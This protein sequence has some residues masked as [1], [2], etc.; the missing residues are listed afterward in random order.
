MKNLQLS[1]IFIFLCI[2]HLQGNL[3]AATNIAEELSI[4]YDHN[5]FEANANDSTFYE[6]ILTVSGGVP[7]YYVYINPQ[8]FFEV[9]VSNEPYSFLATVGEEFS[10]FVKDSDTIP[11]ELFIPKIDIPSCGSLCEDLSFEVDIECQ[12]DGTKILHFEVEGANGGYSVYGNQ[13][14]DT[15]QIGETYW[16]EVVDEQGCTKTENGAYSAILQPKNDW[17]GTT[18][19]EAIH[20]DVL[21][22]DKG[23]C[24]TL[25]DILVSPTCGTIVAFDQITGIV[26]YQVDIG[27]HCTE[28]GFVYEVIDAHG[29]TAQAK[30]VISLPQQDLVVEVSRDCWSASEYLNY[31]VTVEIFS[32]IPPFYI[33]G[34]I[35]TTLEEL[36]SVSIEIENG[37]PYE[38]TVTD[39]LENIFFVS[40]YLN[41]HSECPIVYSYEY[42]N[43]ADCTC[44]K[45]LILHF[46]DL[47]EEG[48]EVTHIDG[49]WNYQNEYGYLSIGD[50]IPAN[51]HIMI[52]RVSTNLNC[53]TFDDYHGLLSGLAKNFC[54]YSAYGFEANDDYI[55]A[56][57]GFPVLIDV[58]ANDGGKDLKVEG[59]YGTLDCGELIEFN[60]ETGIITYLP[61]DN[62]CNSDSFQYKVEDICGDT[63]YGRVYI[64]IESPGELTVQIEKDCSDDNNDFYT[65]SATIL[66]G[67]PPFTI[68][69]S[70]NETL[71]EFDS[72]STSLDVNTP[73][74]VRVEDA[75][76]RIFHEQGASCNSTC[77]SFYVQGIAEVAQCICNQEMAFTL[78]YLITEE[79][80]LGIE[81]T[82][83]NESQ[84]GEIALGDTIPSDA[85]YEINGFFTANECYDFK[86]TDGS[87][88]FGWVNEVCTFV[89]NIE[90][91]NDV[92]TRFLGDPSPILIPVLQN[93][94]GA[95][96]RIT[97]I[98]EQPTCG[99][100]TI[101]NPEGIIS[102]QPNSLCSEDIFKYEVEDNCGNSAVANVYIFS[103]SNTTHL[104]VEVEEDCT[105]VIELGYYI[106]N[107][108]IQNGIAPFV[109]QGSMN[110]T[111]DSKGL[112][113]TTISA[114]TPYSIAI[115][116]AIGNAFVASNENPCFYDEI[117]ATLQITPSYDC[118]IA[119]NHDTIA[120]LTYEAIG[121]HGNYT[122]NGHN[123][124]NFLQNG[125]IYQIEVTDGNGCTAM[126]SDTIACNFT[127]IE[128]PNP[129]SSIPK[130]HLYPNPNNG[131]FTLSLELKQAE[132]VDIEILDITGRVKLWQQLQTLPTVERHTFEQQGLPSGLYF[133]RLSGKDWIWTE[134]VVVN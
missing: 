114:G 104:S 8:T 106:L 12:D 23:D 6:F 129:H 97:Q 51:A 96:L 134:K 39:A 69:G 1:L 34:S 44:E 63:E 112:I 111:V 80:V 66:D 120:F 108:N 83:Y 40:E 76:G 91:A 73:Y 70:I 99:E 102:Y 10:L 68:T 78:P 35:Y 101:F 9:A 58:L 88:L 25:S 74:E 5:C 64:N 2:L 93:D 86:K 37:H 46:N 22:N 81:G 28:D 13:D 130:I 71:N 48:E 122:F 61:D 94:T 62:S 50:T 20:I 47:F 14:G 105:Q 75:L 11:N 27:S 123:P 53:Y 59:L 56:I 4:T 41:C 121:G 84:N 116:D 90:A 85:Y 52:F 119:Q 72:I 21:S 38:I 87:N 42:N 131:N 54:P 55:S 32:G 19:F 110:I 36:G 30:V 45:D 7:P 16:V 31:I 115:T 100:V 128:N 82:W 43:W 18:N 95:N 113:N 98:I 60:E 132:E 65:L 3:L 29:N 117:C 109:F 127:S 124:S 33:S 57:K 77:Q 26:S 17:V 15:L 125:D 133:I 67:Y 92:A 126:V 79:E 107:I 118:F 89:P 103:S 49:I 24:L